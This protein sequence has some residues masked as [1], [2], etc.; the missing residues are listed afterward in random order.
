MPAALRVSGSSEHKTVFRGQRTYTVPAAYRQTSDMKIRSHDGVGDAPIAFW[1]AELVMRTD[2]S[3]VENV[4]RYRL[5]RCRCFMNAGHN[6]ENE[7]ARDETYVVA[8]GE[9]VL[10]QEV[11]TGLLEPG[12]ENDNIS[13][14]LCLRFSGGSKVHFKDGRTSSFSP[15]SPGLLFLPRTET[16]TP[17]AVSRSVSPRT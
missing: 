8:V 13:V 7:G 2:Q 14:K 12:C 17:R 4:W 1:Y 11:D 16:S 6:D 15:G 5:G 9:Q 3:S 10:L